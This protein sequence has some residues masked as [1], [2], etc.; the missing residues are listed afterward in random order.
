M[1]TSASRPIS[2]AKPFFFFFFI[3]QVRGHR[4][5]QIMYF[6]RLV[7]LIG[8][9]SGQHSMVSRRFSNFHGL[10]S[11]HGHLK[12]KKHWSLSTVALRRRREEETT[13]SSTHK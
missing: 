6:D 7:H 10:I 9:V 8:V 1:T 12:K 13:T 4:P 11:Q 3:P 5:T 2:H